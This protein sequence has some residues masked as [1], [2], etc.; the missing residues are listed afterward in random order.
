M[1]VFQREQAFVCR[2]GPRHSFVFTLQVRVEVQYEDRDHAFY[3]HE[4]DRWFGAEMASA[5]VADEVEV[6]ILVDVD[7]K[8]GTVRGA[9]FLTQEVS[10]FGPSDWT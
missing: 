3:D 10:I 5:K 7:R 1:D 8:T 4:D 6:E 2:Y 9:K